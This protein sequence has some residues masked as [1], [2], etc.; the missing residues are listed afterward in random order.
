MLK[1]KVG[2]VG[3]SQKSFPGDREK[4]FARSVSEM[5]KLAQ[6]LDFELYVVKDTVVTQD[7]A[8]RAIK[9]IEDNSVDFLLVQNTTFSGGF[10]APVLA[11]VKNA[12]LGLWAI[13]EETDKGPVPFNSFCSVNM[14][15]SIIGHYLKEYNIPFK[16]FYGNSDNELFDRRFRVTI[17][18]LTAI[19]NIRNSKVA[20]I[21]GIAPGFDDLYF[22]ERKIEKVFG[23]LEINRL[24]EFSEIRDM[25]LSYKQTDIEPLLN[26]YVD[27]ACGIHKKSE[28]LLETSMR[29]YKAYRDFVRENSYNAL[30]VSCWPKFQQEFN[31]SICSVVAKLNDDMIPVA[32]EGDLPSAI[33]MLIL[34]YLSGK[35]PA[36]MDMSAF[37]EEDETVLMWHCGPAPK[38][39]SGE[40]G[41]TLGVNYHALPHEKGKAPNCC[42]VVRDMTF[43]PQHVTIGRIA[44]E[45]EKLF[46]AE[47]DFIDREKNSYCGSRGW[48]GNLELN[49]E[50]IAVRD[51][52]NTVLVRKFQHHYPLVP[53][54]LTDELKEMGAWLGME[55][56]EKAPYTNYLQGKNVQ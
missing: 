8:K 14:Y 23:G 18:A 56:L 22:D 39:L 32:C 53:G 28:A 2:L 9:E 42:G 26:E 19:K 31:L 55:L 4:Q 20:L 36:L 33:S 25:A 30:A 37:D 12:Y 17:S 10:L 52:V 47:G 50:H 48:L 43:K 27:E 46:I 54:R 34:M 1:L 16:W 6:E 49:G 35:S 3:T 51:F 7:D 41:F 13:P 29:F 15:S 11:R 44:G 5:E 24:H 21:G 45:G 40:K 38:N